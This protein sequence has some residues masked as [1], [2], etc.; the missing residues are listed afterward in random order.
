MVINCYFILTGY[1]FAFILQMIFIRA[2]MMLIYISI[3]LSI[4]S[5]IISTY[6]PD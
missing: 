5:G 2:F 3:I 4:N 1:Y 6:F